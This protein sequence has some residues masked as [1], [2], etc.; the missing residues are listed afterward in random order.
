MDLVHFIKHN[1]QYVSAVARM[2]SRKENSGREKILRTETQTF[3]S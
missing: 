2:S 3:A 1:E